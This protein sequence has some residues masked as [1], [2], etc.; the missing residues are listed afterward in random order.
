MVEIFTNDRVIKLCVRFA[1][2]GWILFSLVKSLCCDA[3][4]INPKDKEALRPLFEDWV[5]KNHFGYVL[6]GD[7]A[8]AIAGY[9]KIT[10]I[11]NLLYGYAKTKF[12]FQKSWSVF[13]KYSKLLDSENFIILKNKENK[14]ADVEISIITIVNKRKFLETVKDHLTLFTVTLGDKISPED[15][16][17]KVSKRET[18]LWEILHKDEE[19]YGILLGYGVEGSRTF[20]RKM[21]IGP[22]ID[23]WYQLIRS[24]C[25]QVPKP[26]ANFSSIKNEYTWL[27]N[28]FVPF[29]LDFP[30]SFITPPC[31]MTIK[32]SKEEQI[33]K[34]K[35]K[36]AHKKLLK[37]YSNQD[38]VS[39]MIKQLT[40]NKNHKDFIKEQC[41][42]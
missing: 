36:I 20:K 12:N 30:F 18:S 16:L 7:K 4:E 26:E 24:F 3:F 35:Y 27:Q 2:I 13:E 25:L 1:L 40:E 29:N 39:T 41:C 32:D 38:V 23:P 22:F 42:L 31:F 21:E 28:N 34:K 15:L 11:G 37:I 8:I 17:K 33:L 10:P 9:F 19:L 5:F 6:N 14:I